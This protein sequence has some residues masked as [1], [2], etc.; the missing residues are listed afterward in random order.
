MDLK[1]ILIGIAATALGGFISWRLRKSNY[2]K[3][4]GPGCA[5]AF[6]LLLALIGLISFALGFLL[7][8]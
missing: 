7:K 8:S 1:L 4:L 2:N 5:M 6:G 3:E